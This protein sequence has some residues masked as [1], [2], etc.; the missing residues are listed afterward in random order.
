MLS[1]QTK[2]GRG[3]GRDIQHARSHSKNGATRGIGGG[4]GH[5]SEEP[6][7]DS[8]RRRRIEGICTVVVLWWQD[9]PATVRFR[10][11]AGTAGKSLKIASIRVSGRRQR[12]GGRGERAGSVIPIVLTSIVNFILSRSGGK[13]PLRLDD[14]STPNLRSDEGRDHS[15][16]IYLASNTT[17]GTH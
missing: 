4:R 15:S 1:K 17:Q 3:D 6:G 9:E 2:I 13:C 12:S 14:P 7:G 11:S 8:P 16:K 10:A 5:Y